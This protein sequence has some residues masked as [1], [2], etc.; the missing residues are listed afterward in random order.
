ETILRAAPHCKRGAIFTDGGSTKEGIVHA[1]E[2]G[3]RPDLL[4]VPAHPLAGS[5]KNGVA[6]ARADLFEERLTILTPISKTDP[7][8]LERVEAFWRALGSR[9]ARLDPGK[10]DRVLA[11]TSHLPHVIASALAGM[12]PVEWLEYSAGGFRDTT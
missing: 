2:R 6:H 3:S 5:E 8:A 10:H 11:G 9:T 1:V 7:G 4:F 12:I